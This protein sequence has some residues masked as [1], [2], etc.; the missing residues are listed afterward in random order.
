MVKDK[1][2]LPPPHKTKHIPPNSTPTKVYL[3]Y[4]IQQLST[5]STVNQ[6]THKQARFQLHHRRQKITP[7]NILPVKKDPNSSKQRRIHANRPDSDERITKTENIIFK[8]RTPIRTDDHQDRDHRHDRLQSSNL[9]S[10]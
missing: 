3:S 7:T 4:P 2:P 10:N 1:E 8:Q 6:Y 5:I 9:T